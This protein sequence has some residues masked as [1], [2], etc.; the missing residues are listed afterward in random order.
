LNDEKESIKFLP[1]FNKINIIVEA[2]NS[3]KSRFMRYSMTYEKI[4]GVVDF[5][6]LKNL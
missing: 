4:Q 6:N 5:K 1:N 2:N 3:G